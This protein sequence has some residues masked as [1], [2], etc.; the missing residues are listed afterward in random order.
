MHSVQYGHTLWIMGVRTSWLL[1]NHSPISCITLPQVKMCSSLRWL[2]GIVAR[3][4]AD[5]PT[6]AASLTNMLL[7]PYTVSICHVWSLVCP[8]F[9]RKRP[10]DFS[11]RGLGMRL[12]WCLRIVCMQKQNYKVSLITEQQSHSWWHSTV[13]LLFNAARDSAEKWSCGPP[14]WS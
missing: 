14:D 5:S 1:P 12:V 11:E 4:Q 10:L 13:F 2:A 9:F 3:K 6:H 8:D 7:D